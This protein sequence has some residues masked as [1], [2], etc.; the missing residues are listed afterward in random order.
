L[1]RELGV[2]A[3]TSP[4][5]ARFRLSNVLTVLALV[6]I[7]A[8]ALW[9]RWDR[10]D[11]AEFGNDQASS[12]GRASDF[13]TQGSFPVYGEITSVGARQGPVEIWTLA[14]P[15]ALSR[16]PRV[17]TGFVGLLQVLAVLGTYLFAA[18]YFGRAP[19][20]VAAALFATNPWA[21]N[22]GRKIWPDDLM[23]LF[24]LLFFSALFA[25]VV[26]RR[27]LF[28][29]LACLWLATLALI[30]PASVL[31]APLLGLVLLVFWRRLGL[32]ALLLGVAL[33]LLLASPFLYY[34]SQHGFTSVRTYLGVGTATGA[35]IDLESLKMIATLATAQYFPGMMGVSYRGSWSL[36]DL[37]PQNEVSL[38]LL[39]AGL[40]YCLVRLSIWLWRRRPAGDAW[41][42]YAL[43]GLWFAVPVLVSLRHANSYYPNYFQ[44]VYP[45]QF[46]LIALALTAPRA[47]LGRFR[48][49]SRRYL[50]LSANALA[51]V[52]AAWLCLS[53]VYFFRTYLDGIVSAGP[54]GPYGVPLIFSQQAVDTA[55]ALSPRAADGTVYVQANLQRQTLDYLARPDLQLRLVEPPDT[56]LLPPNLD[57][58][59]VLM[60][61]AD[62]AAPGRPYDLVRDGASRLKRLRG[63]GFEE[64]PGTAVAGPD[65]HYYYRFF[66]LPAGKSQTV[67]HSFAPALPA[68]QLANGARL[69]GYRFGSP[70]LAGGKATLDLL[71]QMPEAPRNQ[72]REI[73]Y[74]I[75]VHAVD[76]LGR[77]L[78]ADEREVPRSQDWRSGELMISSFEIDLPPD[79]GPALAWFDVGAYSRYDRAPVP[80]QDASGGQPSPA[81]RL[82]SIKILPPAPSA[83]PAAAVDFRF[84]SSLALVGY[85][86][87]PRQP[88]PG[89]ELG[90]TLRWRTIAPPTADYTVSIQLLDA[91]GRLVA[92][93][94]SPP[95]GG[96]YPTSVWGTGEEIADRHVLALPRGLPA[97]EYRLLVVVYDPADQKRLQLAGGGDYAPLTALPLGAGQ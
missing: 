79:A 28:L 62:D 10:L 88:A 6:G 42:K 20:L 41:E 67:L 78:G 58:D 80:W 74:N 95:V 21:V 89:G 69:Q 90:V 34:D 76:S 18:R 68:S 57:K 96:R 44:I 23:P 82:G 59:L 56:V 8:L 64:I 3:T 50:Q 91:S 37:T 39:Y 66:C 1:D 19:G 63:L 49:P 60:L 24:A 87:A 85:E 92:Q 84:G 4:R 7:L 27:R 29:G 93:H 38:W 2:Q 15:A 16:D 30:H 86:L 40:A 22:Y 13:A 97:G 5:T 77:D 31:F 43:L 54:Q 33:S 53:N 70:A 25:A 14:V 35:S 73:E 65:G 45:I 48:L 17:A 81:Y 26:Q 47:L 9:L 36:P 11:Y 46:V 83:Q 94:D 32:K 52:V 71:W 61:G 75:F 72:I 55:R 12:L 51:L